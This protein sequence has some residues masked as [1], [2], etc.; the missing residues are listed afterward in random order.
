MQLQIDEI[1][2]SGF[3][4]RDAS[5]QLTQLGN[6]HPRF[7]L[8]SG[9]LVLPPPLNHLKLIQLKC[10]Q[11]TWSATL[12][13]C[14]QGRGR[15]KH[16]VLRDPAFDFS[17][18]V[19]NETARLKISHLPLF[20]GT[21]S[22]DAS[23]YQ[24]R[25]QITLNSRGV[26][27][28][29][30]QKIVAINALQN[31]EGRLSSRIK[32]KGQAKKISSVSLQLSP[33]NVNLSALNDTLLSDALDGRISLKATKKRH[34]HWQATLEF[35]SGGVFFDPLF[36]DFSQQDDMF[37]SLQGVFAEKNMRLSLNQFLV[38]QGALFNI[39]GQ[40]DIKLHTQPVLQ[41]AQ[42]DVSVPSLEQVVPVYVWPFLETGSLESLAVS[43]GMQSQISLNNNQPVQV[44]LQ[45]QHLSVDDP[46]QRFALDNANANIFWHAD[47]GQRQASFL[48]WQRL[49]I[50]AIPIDHGRLDFAIY[51]KH[52]DLIRKAHLPILG[53]VFTIEHF[54]FEFLK[55]GDA[56]VHFKGAVSDLSLAKLSKT[57]GWKVLSGELNGVI[58]SVRYRNKKL[59]LDG[60]LVVNVFNG[61]VRISKLAS[62]GMFTDFARFYTD[63]EF[64]NLDLHA[65]THKFDVGGIEG[66]LSG[67]ARDVYLENWQP[68]SFYAWLGTPEGD[69]SERRISQRAVNSIASIGGGGAVDALSRGFMRFFDEFGYDELGM[70]CYLKNGVCQVMGVQAAENGYY[71]IKGG[72]LPR[73]DVIGYNPRIDWN[74][75][76][77][78]LQRVL[79]SSTLVIQ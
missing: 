61:E 24:G 25:W 77:Q 23:E 67:F 49:T 71:L 32:A 53:G 72:G 26:S 17:L 59:D 46:K 52:F 55:V 65:I 37:A 45:F 5:L 8:V 69:D 48:D 42:F 18:T 29:H 16:K 3:K 36:I 51:D 28:A 68:I 27:L 30:L 35:I 76:V 66:R 79:N 54:G 78:R 34:W 75:L 56:D 44:G 31:I 7:A 47:K 4:I 63:V 1:S 50:K 13:S 39:Q 22:I 2:A 60:E 41:S 64:S 12:I 14:Q 73:I 19:K 15:V 38:K 10:R 74:V 40:A 70:G 62:S 33:Q 43:G 57:L 58:P 21:M 6:A 9:E 20:A 11:F